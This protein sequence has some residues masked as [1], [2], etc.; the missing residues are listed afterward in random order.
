M[1]SHRCR[2]LDKDFHDKNYKLPNKLRIE[3]IFLSLIRDSTK[4]NLCKAYL[5]VKK[6]KSFEIRNK[7]KMAH[8]AHCFQL[9]SGGLATSKARI[10]KKGK[11]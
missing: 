6:L 5:K 11:I 1:K 4:K 3:E 2:N 8:T 7:T 10:T 9:C